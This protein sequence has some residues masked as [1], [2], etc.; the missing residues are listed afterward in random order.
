MLIIG[1]LL[2]KN[3][4]IARQADRERNTLRA[5][6]GN[7]QIALDRQQL[8]FGMKTF[9]WAVRNAMLHNKSGEINE[10]FTTLV[11]DRGVQE[12][13]LV[14]PSGKVT[15]STNRKNQGILFVSRFPGYLLQQQDVYFNDKNPYELSAPVTGPNKRLGTLVMFYKPASL[16]PKVPVSQ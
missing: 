16:L 15:L 3:T 11:K 2:Y 9:V 6:I 10:Y 4:Q 12:V 8:T 5:S 14:D 1:Y 7:N 13:L